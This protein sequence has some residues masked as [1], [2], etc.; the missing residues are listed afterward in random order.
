[1]AARIGRNLGTDDR[2]SAEAAVNIARRSGLFIAAF[3][4]DLQGKARDQRCAWGGQAFRGLPR[5]SA[6]LLPNAQGADRAPCLQKNSAKLSP[7]CQKALPGL[8]AD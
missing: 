5:G 8:A 6:E 7:A 1:M 2:I 3:A 4:D